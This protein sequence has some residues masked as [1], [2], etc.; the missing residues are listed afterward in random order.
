M[1]C[2]ILP[3]SD[4]QDIRMTIRQRNLEDSLFRVE[5][6]PNGH[7]KAILHKGERSTTMISGSTLVCFWWGNNDI[8][9]HFFVINYGPLFTFFQYMQRITG[10]RIAKN[11]QI[12]LSEIMILSYMVC[13]SVSPKINYW[14]AVILFRLRLKEDA[15]QRNNCYLPGITQLFILRLP[16]SCSVLR[17]WVQCDLECSNPRP[18]P[19]IKLTRP[20]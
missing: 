5:W 2:Q 12:M 8:D 9:V 6:S 7:P 10:P 13:H 11:C 17:Y 20:N 3:A 15:L 14:C 1:F 18:R 16:V 4:L 19:S